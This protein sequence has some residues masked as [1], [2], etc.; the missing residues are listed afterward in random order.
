[1]GRFIGLVII[2]WLLLFTLRT[3]QIGGIDPTFRDK[4]VQLFKPLRER[5]VETLDETLPYPQSALLSGILIGSQER[6]PYYLKDQMKATSTIHIA[7]VS[8][9]NLT[10]LA[11]FIMS[12]VSF[13]GRRKTIALTLLVVG[14]YSLLTGF[15]VPAIRASIMVALAFLAQILG[16]ERSGWW[17]LLIT[18][19]AML[20]YNPNW[21]LSISFQLSF[22]ATMGVV[23]VAPILVERFKAVPQIIKQ[24]LAVTLAAQAMV[25]P[26]IVYNFG[27]LSLVGVLANLFVLWTIPIIMVT[28]FI[29]LVLGLLSNFLGSLFGWI[30][31]I[32]LTYFIDL[33]QFFS[34]IPG[35]SVGVGET[36]ILL[37]VGYYLILGAVIW[38][39]TIKNKS[40]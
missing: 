25:L 16:K 26:V 14:F 11:G 18:A 37:W 1:M 19:G 29:S 17:V 21:L 20:L 6:F 5:L 27:Q 34:K 30:P 35:A 7:V 31:A 22:L 9:Q 3:L 10:M 12:I 33:V 36:G 8:G 4:E 39:T 15:Q 28:G 13:L 23:V 40:N 38:G 2:L 24:D 32:L